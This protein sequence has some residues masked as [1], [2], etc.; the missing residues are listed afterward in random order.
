MIG[1][2]FAGGYAFDDGFFGVWGGGVEFDVE[3]FFHGADD[4]EAGAAV[5]HNAV[6]CRA[7][8]YLGPVGYFCEDL[9]KNQYEFFGA[10][11]EEAVEADPL[12]I[13]P[14]LGPG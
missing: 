2:F 10:A 6:G 12:A 8:E 5:K 13:M 3:P 9:I 7:D 11:F 1:E 14:E 4:E